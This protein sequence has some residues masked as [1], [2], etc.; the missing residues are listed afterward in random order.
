M[1]PKQGFRL[2]FIALLAF[3]TPGIPEYLTGSW[4]LSTFISTPV[5]F[6]AFLALNLGIYTAGALLIREFA[7][8]LRK[9]WVSIFILGCAYG[10]M[11]EAIALHTFFQISGSPVGILGTYGRVAGVDWVWAFGLM[12]YH[13]VFSITLPLMLVSAAYPQLRGKMVTGTGGLLASGAIYAFTVLILNY[14]VNR[15]STRP[16]PTHFDYLLFLFI[17]LFL[18]LIA[19]LV[20]RNLMQ[21]RGKTGT[22]GIPLYFLGLLVYPVYNVFAL[23]PVDPIVITRLSPLMDILIHSVLFMFIGFGIVYFMPKEENGRQKFALGAG[24][25]TSLMVV[26]LKEEFTRVAPLI[27]IVMIIALAFLF[28]LWTI[29]KQLENGILE[30]GIQPE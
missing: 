15:T 22:G 11:E 19:Y 17:S 3:A 13:A 18:V 10:I 24:V 1:V 20:P 9:G 28:R 8:K 26:S 12:A 7:V 5:N 6:L 23:I 27:I 21:F 29:V 30:G 16:V 2:K 25:L 4:K 14:I